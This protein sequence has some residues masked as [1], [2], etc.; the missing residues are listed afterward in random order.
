M[1]E[2]S[3]VAD[4]AGIFVTFNDPD[5]R[6]SIRLDSVICV[7]DAEQVFAN[8]DYPHLLDLK[9]RQLG[10]A[11]MVIL[12]KVDLAGKEQVK[13][14]RSW[15]DEQMNRVRIVEASFCEVPLEILM[16][17]GR[18]DPIKA[19]TDLNNQN[20]STVKN[21][22]YDHGQAFSTWSYVS[23]KKFS[24]ESLKEMIRRELP[25]DIYRCKGFVFTS[26]AP[27]Q[28]AV[29]QVVG[30]RSDIVLLNDWNN[31]KPRTRIVAIGSKGN[32]NEKAL[33]EKFDSCIDQLN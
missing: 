25:A 18:F 32:I 29:L 9:L 31:Q 26:E 33:Q 27:G 11:D 23:D 22:K 6:D 24:L 10:C 20:N 14:V 8:P 4:P 15:I 12:N 21:Q 19:K 1:L 28:R 3:G 2:A 16:A 7:I 30:R 17:V 5:L 13:K